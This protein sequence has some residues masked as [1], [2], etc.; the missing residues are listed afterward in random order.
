M[1]KSV[2]NMAVL[3]RFRI[4]SWRVD[5]VTCTLIGSRGTVRIEHKAMQVLAYLAAHADEVVSRDEL[6]SAVWP[7]VAVTDHVLTV[8]ISGLRKAL[9]DD[10]RAP[11]FVVTV[12]RRGFRLIASVEALPE[13]SLDADRRPWKEMV[14]LAVTIALVA[15]LITLRLRGSEER[16]SRL[17]STA[18][19]APAS[20]RA[21]EVA[22][23]KGRLHLERA[24]NGDVGL[25]FRY[26]ERAAAADASFAP[27][28]SGMAICYLLNPGELDKSRS[29]AYK[30]ASSFARRAQ[31]L[32]PMLTETLAALGALAFRYEWRWGAAESLLRQ[33]LESDPEA[34]L[35]HQWYAELLSATG[36]HDAAEA[37]MRKAIALDPLA[38]S[39]RYGLAWVLFAARRYDDSLTVLASLTPTERQRA[40]YHWMRFDIEERRGNESVAIDA[41][42][43]GLISFGYDPKAVLALERDAQARG[44]DVLHRWRLEHAIELF[45]GPTVSLGWLAAVHLALGE[46]A[47]ALEL[48][49]QACARREPFVTWIAVDPRFDGLRHDPRFIAMVA[50]LARPD[51]S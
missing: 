34:I 26:F 42:L 31:A 19:P 36:R 41:Y 5:P 50:R 30:A 6:L 38:P 14:A 43:R 47:R 44:I 10:A 7:D 28:W 2:P 49:E 9:G 20:T 15:G 18:S 4:G 25:A 51:F 3:R 23:S 24:E 40:G 16:H 46:R 33:A 17:G 13:E 8:A 37:V 32:D 35:A 27:A 29:E 45:S 12:P 22:Y 39:L 21:A 48:L 1:E 11:S